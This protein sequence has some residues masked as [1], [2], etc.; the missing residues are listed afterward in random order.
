MKGGFAGIL[1]DLFSKGSLVSELQ[2][3]NTWVKLRRSLRQG[4]RIMVNVGGSCVESEDSSRD[5]KVV[6]EE[7]LKA[8]HCAFG[9]DKVHVLNLGNRKDDSSIAMTGRF[10][11]LD[12][13][14]GVLPKPLTCYVDMWMPYN[15]LVC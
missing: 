1:V 10:P 11:D 5:G 6:M 7:T 3:V 9:D 2:D 4:G 13:W 14:K 15:S 8:M 12:K